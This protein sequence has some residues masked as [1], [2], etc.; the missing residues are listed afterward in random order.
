MPTFTDENSALGDLNNR[1]KIPCCLPA[2]F[3]ILISLGAYLFA[4]DAMVTDCGYLLF[5]CSE[6]F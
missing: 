4:R 3:G 1:V 5:Y 2:I 6:L